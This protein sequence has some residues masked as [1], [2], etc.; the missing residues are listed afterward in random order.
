MNGQGAAIPIA[1]TRTV[2]LTRET[3]RPSDL[4]DR[5]LLQRLI[6]EEESGSR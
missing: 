1:S 4:A 3:I 2:V 5:Q 6:E